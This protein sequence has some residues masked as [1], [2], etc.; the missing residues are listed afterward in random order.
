MILSSF[1]WGYTITQI[2]A[3]HLAGIWSAQRLLS[4]GIFV[5]GL[6]TLVVP[7]GSYHGSWISVCVC[8]VGMGLCQGCLLPCAQTLIAKWAP[9]NERARLGK[10]FGRASPCFNNSIFFFIFLLFKIVILIFKNSNILDSLSVSLLVRA[11][12]NK[13]QKLFT[14]SWLVDDL[15][16]KLNSNDIFAGLVQKYFQ[17]ILSLKMK[18]TIIIVSFN[19]TIFLLLNNKLDNY[20]SNI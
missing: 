13:E 16:L 7:F 18:I 1:F 11:S 9:P 4:M 3:G 19:T 5:C 10:L 14:L 20:L 8:R 15:F 17:C 6:L 2:P 12:R